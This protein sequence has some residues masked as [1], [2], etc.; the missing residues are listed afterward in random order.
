MN[1]LIQRQ[2]P[3]S[4][5][6]LLL[7]GSLVVSRPS[8]A[9]ESC[10]RFVGDVALSR[11]VAAALDRTPPMPLPWQALMAQ[12]AADPT[13]RPVSR[14]SASQSEPWVGNLEGSL[15][16]A[17]GEP[18]A[19][20]N[21]AGICLGIAPRHLR[22]LIGSPLAALSLSNNHSHDFGDRAAAATHRQL[23]AQGI[24]PLS[25]DSSIDDSPFRLLRSGDI[26]WALVAINLI[27]RS[28]DDI[29]AAMLRLRLRIGLARASTPWV[30]VLPHWGREYDGS[31]GPSEWAQAELWSRWGARLIVGSHPH[32]IGDHRCQ[33]DVATYYSLGNFLFDQ[34]QPATHR[35]LMLRC[36]A[37]GQTQLVCR[38]LQ[39]QRSAQV[40]WPQL[41]EPLPQ[42]DCTLDRKLPR[43]TVHQPASAPDPMAV[44]PA[45][46]R[47]PRRAA[48]RFVQSFR[49]LGPQ[50]FF[51]LHAQYSAFDQ[52]TALRPYVFAIR[53]GQPIDVWRGT[54][55]SW[56]LL[57][58]RLIQLGDGRE[59][60]CALHRGD[61]F[62]RRDPQISSQRR[63]HAVYAWSGFGFRRVDEA[64]ALALCQTY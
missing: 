42:L 53:D 11:D 60:L 35:G 62:V 45:W 24:L 58:A 56:P 57:Y 59:R 37:R 22:L 14:A 52:E 29:D 8:Q 49:S 16:P 6:L 30:V 7:L 55:L 64:D 43:A 32:V 5:V 50:H 2:R 40:L 54:A 39:T 17:P 21:P 44:E 38:A 33:G 61:S 13:P 26:T 41:A 31:G 27:N 15:L 25:D 12:R 1:R 4:L 20:Q 51:A 46:Q 36:C 28:R 10:L 9:D 19:C 63:F 47:H 3:Q 18:A 48:L 23:L 34:P